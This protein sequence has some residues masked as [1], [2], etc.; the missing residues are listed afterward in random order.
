MTLMSMETHERVRQLL[1]SRTE[2]LRKLL[3]VTGVAD[4]HRLG[5]TF[6][7]TYQDEA[8]VNLIRPVLVRRLVADLETVHTSIRNQ[9]VEPDPIPEEL[10]HAILSIDQGAV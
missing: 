3:V 9:G 4:G 5:V 10:K 6:G 8:T 1:N 7:G 2:V